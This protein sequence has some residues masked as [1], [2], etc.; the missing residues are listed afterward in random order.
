MEKVLRNEYEKE[1]ITKDHNKEECSHFDIIQ[2]N[3]INEQD[4]YAG[5]FIQDKHDLICEDEKKKV[6]KSDF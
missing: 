3:S 4:T 6:I 5:T 2:F 1:I